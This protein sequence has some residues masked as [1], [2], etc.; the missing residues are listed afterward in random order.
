MTESWNQSTI[1]IPEKTIVEQF[2]E[3]VM[4]TP[5][6]EA[7]VMEEGRERNAV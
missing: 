1:A 7:V 2:E 4:K 5:K 6:R 3:Q